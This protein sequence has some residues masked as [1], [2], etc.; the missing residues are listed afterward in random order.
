MARKDSTQTKEKE[1]LELDK[2]LQE[3]VERSEYT[4]DNIQ[5]L[6]GLEAVRKRPGM[7][8]GDTDNGSGLH[9]M[10]YELVDNAIDEALA[11]YCDTIQVTIHA[12]DMVTVQDNGRGIPVDMHEKM[13]KSAAEVIMTELHAGGK[14]DQNSYK[15]SGGLHGVGVSVVN[16][17][18]EWLELEIKRDGK[19][20]EQR[21]ERGLPVQELTPVGNTD[22]TGS[23]ITFKPDAEVFDGTTYSF[24][25]LSQ[26][27][28]ELSYLNGGVEIIIV[29]ERDGKSHDFSF[30]GG[31]NSFVRAL[32]ENKQP[33]HDE[34]I[35]IQQEDEEEG[36]TVEVSLQWNDSFNRN[37]FCYTNN[38]R[39]EDG[40]S[41][42][43][44]LKG[45]LTRTVNTYGIS[46]DIIDDSLKGDDVREGLTAVLSVKMPEPK[47]SGQTKEKLVSNEIKGSVESIVNEYL[48]YYFNEH[49]KVA[50][51]IV[52]KA[53]QASR[54]REAARKARDIARKSA[55]NKV[56]SLPGKLADCQS[57][58]PEKSE[59]FVVEGDSAGGSAKQ[60]RERK[61]QAILPLRGKIL[62]VEKAR[63]DK[64]LS[65]NEISALISALG[66]GIG[67]D[68]FDLSKLRYHR[69]ILMTDADVDG[70]HI[71]TLLL[72]FFYR[73]MPEI[74]ERGYLYIAKP[75][76]YAVRRG[77]SIN[78]LEDESERDQFLLNQ[79]KEKVTIRGENGIVLEGEE[80]RDFVKDLIDYQ[81]RLDVL[82]RQHDRRIIDQL[83]QAELTLDDFKDNQKLEKRAQAARDELEKKHPNVRWQQPRIQES[84]EM[85]DFYEL[86]WESRV[87][88]TL[89]TTHLSRDFLKT[90][91][92]RKLVD[93]WQRFKSLGTPVLVE[94]S[95]QEDT[96][97]EME[98]LVDFVLEQ[99]SKGR[100]IQRYKGLGEMNPEQL[101]ET[102]LNPE[103][104]TLQQVRIEDAVEADELFTILMGDQVDP[105]RQFIQQHADEADN[106]DI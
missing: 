100:S 44:G 62:N 7:Y 61:F 103:T 89:V 49:P 97:Q 13:G 94:A 80:L 9:H 53:L 93:I 25:I 54:A 17:L 10:V 5:V 74:I 106:L 41:H 50:K 63:F 84:E 65:N 34:P 99:G 52:K 15:V 27:L 24:D 64:I 4:A 31:I 28:R 39:N 47:F 102:T 55:L 37:I 32:N 87:A 40:G 90:D 57:R 19:V 72:T 30:E 67:E 14:F 88:G 29:D 82:G 76:L 104:R 56:G 2:S 79:A 81:S 86:F 68:H 36:V 1:D 16:A 51:T 92:N 69:I 11:G 66:C 46:N 20:W 33:L 95:R 59:L 3:A 96:F 22:K 71:R 75:P 23:K 6:E 58:K 48:G 83:I 45:A 35:Y 26:R 98:P 8:I 60:G 73:Q 43:S 70:A 38:I 21:Y 78:Y 42:L 101:W 18:S 77:R 12:D 85:E 105:R 91:V